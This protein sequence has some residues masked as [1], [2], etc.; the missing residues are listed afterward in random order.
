MK[1]FPMQPRRKKSHLL[2]TAKVSRG[3]FD[4]AL[5]LLYQ[6]GLTSSQRLKGPGRIGLS[7]ALPPGLAAKSLLRRLKE[8]ERG[9]GRPLFHE[10]KIQ[11]V[12]RGDWSRKYQRYLKPFRLI[13]ATPNRPDLEV[14]PR[15]KI[16]RRLKG[17]TLYIEA[18]LAFG[19]GTHSTTRLAAELLSQAMES[20]RRPAV[21]DVGCGTGILAMAA[22]RLGAGKVIAV[23]NDPEALATA[24][25]NFKRNRISEIRPLLTLKGL[26]GKFPI[27]VSNIG[28]NVILE[29][30]SEFKRLLAAQGDLILTGLLYRDIKELLRVY[31][32]MEVVRRCNHKGWAAVWL[33][34]QASS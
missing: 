19:T 11:K 14:D 24:V 6:S 1:G 15:G 32:G 23:D 16:P 10:A 5:G 31:R 17:N 22:K 26:K 3:D 13:P 7:A 9:L 29:L 30:K 18:G 34:K 20:R 4:L 21:L 33:R 25:E 27:I 8:L 28:L 12:L 2:L